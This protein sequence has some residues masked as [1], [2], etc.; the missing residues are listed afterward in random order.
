MP[1]GEVWLTETGGIVKFQLAE[2]RTLFGFDERRAARN[3]D[4]MF[5][6]ARRYRGRVRRLYI[7]HWRAPQGENRF[8]AGLLR[9]NGVARP[10]YHTMVARLRRQSRYFGR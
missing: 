3:T 9:A 8:D 7:Y 10:A 2:G 1:R 5:D 6:L 4:R